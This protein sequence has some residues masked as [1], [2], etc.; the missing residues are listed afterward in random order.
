M[1]AYANYYL[2]FYPSGIKTKKQRSKASRSQVLLIEPQERILSKA[3]VEMEIII[4]NI[5]ST[6]N[7]PPYPYLISRVLCFHLTWIADMHDG[8]LRDAKSGM[9]RKS[10]FV[11]VLFWVQY[12]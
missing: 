11:F 10:G 1:I 7:F 4:F 6:L 12:P 9:K 5:P 2:P 3:K 8:S